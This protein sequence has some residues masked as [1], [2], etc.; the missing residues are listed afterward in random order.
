MVKVH[1]WL[2]DSKHVGHTSL[3][4][5]KEYVSFWPKDEAGK[6]DIKIKRSQPGMLIQSL[7]EDIRNEGGRQPITVELPALNEEAVLD[8]IAKIQQSTPRYQ[9]ARNNCSH[10]RLVASRKIR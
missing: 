6:K 10:I 4:I 1:V 7:R 8:F 5:K 9:I 3:T 2:P